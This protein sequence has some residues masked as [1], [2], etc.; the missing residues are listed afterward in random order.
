MYYNQYIIELSHDKTLD[1][2]REQISDQTKEIVVN[3]KLTPE[4]KG[5]LYTSE[6][7]DSLLCCGITK[8]YLETLE[9]EHYFSLLQQQFIQ[10]VSLAEN[11]KKQLATHYITDLTS[12]VIEFLSC[13]Q[14]TAM[15]L[16]C[17]A[18]SKNDDG[19]A[20]QVA[21]LKQQQEQLNI[22]SFYLEDNA[23][24]MDILIH[25]VIPIDKQVLKQLGNFI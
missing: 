13:L 4:D 10:S 25:E 1:S 14:N 19:I 17:L 11:F 8:L 9:V 5:L 15:I 12:E 24:C 3:I 23:L 7:L 20:K 22:T 16:E 21:L 18:L 6:N 2:V